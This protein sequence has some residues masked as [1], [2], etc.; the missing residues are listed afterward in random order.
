MQMDG[1]D[2]YGLRK[3]R[4]PICYSQLAFSEIKT[5]NEINQS[6]CHC[7]TFTPQQNVVDQLF[8]I[9]DL[10]QSPDFHFEPL[11]WDIMPNE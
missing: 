6:H 7:S 1:G 3:L 8:E 4:R 11:K 9:A 2:L 5:N 10:S